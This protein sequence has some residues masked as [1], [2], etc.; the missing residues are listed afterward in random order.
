[1]SAN[2]SAETVALFEPLH[3]ECTCGNIKYDIVA[4]PAGQPF[5][6]HCHNCKRQTGSMFTSNLIVLRETL[7]ITG[8]YKVWSSEEDRKARGDDGKEWGGLF[9]PE[10]GTQICALPDNIPDKAILRI[11]TLDPKDLM[12]L[13]KP[14]T[15]MFCARKIGW[16]ADV[17]GAAQFEEWP[18]RG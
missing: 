12:R 14:V 3:G 9:C 13:G 11:G 7:K 4:R 6:C 17:E 15:E 18:T 8:K 5:L 2:L 1:M 16:P 10:C